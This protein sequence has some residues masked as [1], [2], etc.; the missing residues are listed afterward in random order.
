MKAVILSVLTLIFLGLNT[1]SAQ[2]KVDAK[3]CLQKKYSKS[4]IKRFST[5][6]LNYQLFVAEN[7][8]KLMA[9]PEGK[10]E[11]AFTQIDVIVNEGVCVYDLPIQVKS[12]EL[13][14]IV[15][16]NGKLLVVFSEKMLKDKYNR[17]QVNEAN[18]KKY[19]ATLKN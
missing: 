8:V 13:Q 4:D 9:Y 3:A 10:P 1:L 12:N 7:A 17:K 15:T 6:E 2:E 19:E 18:R 5:D 14:N 16:K 11:S